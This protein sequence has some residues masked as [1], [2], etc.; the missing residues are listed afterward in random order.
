MR[1][2]VDAQLPPTLARWIASQPGHEAE[3]VAFVLSPSEMDEAIVSYAVAKADVVV[4]KDADF[5]D[6]APPPQLLVVATGNIPNTALIAVFEERFA[7]AVQQLLGGR[8]VVEI[9]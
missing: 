7:A 3:H 1:F 4:T 2:L 6:L 9:S 8:A 5:L